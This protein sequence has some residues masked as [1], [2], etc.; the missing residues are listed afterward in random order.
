VLSEVLAGLPRSADPNLLVGYETADDAAVYRVSPEIAVIST[1]DYITPVVDDP[2]WFGRIAAANSLSD[3]WAMGGRPIMALNLVNFPAKTLDLGL[4]REMLRGGAE[5]VAES[6]A[7]LAGGHS[8][9]DPEPKY[10]LAVT[11]VVHPDRVLANCG[12]RVGDAIVLTKPVGNGVIFNANR[13]GKYPAADLERDVLPVA[14]A[15]NK[16]AC[17]AALKYEVHALTDV[18]GFGLAGHA[19][20]MAA[21]S[22]VRLVLS[23]AA[24]PLYPGAVEMYA[25]GVGTSANAGNRALCGE[26]LRFDAALSRERQEILFDPQ[27]SGGL[28]AALPEAEARELVRELHAAGLPWAAVVG[29]AEAGDAGITVAS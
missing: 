11:G 18:T 26:R 6:G 23:W 9:E 3:V 1:V 12:V 13:A 16:A 28:L 25:A 4:L 29:H 27:T 5:K 21:G 24:L 19:M 2:L 20:E 15:L 10:G 14:A 22:C 8:V 7:C 17:E